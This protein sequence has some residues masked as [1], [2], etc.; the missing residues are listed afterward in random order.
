MKLQ[1]SFFCVFFF[2]YVSLGGKIYLLL[3]VYSVF[4]NPESSKV[5]F[6]RL[7][8][9]IVL[10]TISLSYIP[11]NFQFQSRQCCLEQGSCTQRRLTA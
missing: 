9:L 6:G 5:H 11:S 8:N 2:E 3:S 7:A 1:Q 4:L 10:E